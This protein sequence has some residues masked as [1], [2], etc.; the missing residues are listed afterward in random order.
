MYCCCIKFVLPGV[1]S[2]FFLRGIPLLAPQEAAALAASAAAAAAAA[3]GAGRGAP[4]T[5]GRRRSS[6]GTVG[7]AASGRRQSF[8]PAAMRYAHSTAAVL[9]V[10]PTELR[11]EKK[12]SRRISFGVDFFFLR[13]VLTHACVGG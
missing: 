2:L 13:S 6:M 11:V 7:G 1:T 4:R 8:A 3:T 5:P 12:N 10:L 9:L